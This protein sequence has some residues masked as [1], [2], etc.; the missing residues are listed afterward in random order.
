[1]Q[2]ALA[3]FERLAVQ[4]G[5]ETVARIEGDLTALASLVDVKLSGIEE[6]IA[7]RAGDPGEGPAQH[8]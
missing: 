4:R 1:M 6:T 5:Q 2:E 3:K 7:S 8:D